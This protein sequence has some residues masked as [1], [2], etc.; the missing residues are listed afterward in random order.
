MGCCQSNCMRDCKPDIEIRMHSRQKSF[1]EVL[2]ARPENNKSAAPSIFIKNYV[3][4]IPDL[5]KMVPKDKSPS[6]VT[7]QT[8]DSFKVFNFKKL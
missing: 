2:L 4:Q 6:Y 8:D 5:A 3:D 1:G 7:G